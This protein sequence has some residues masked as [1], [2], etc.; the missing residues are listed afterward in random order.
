MYITHVLAY[1]NYLK[2]YGQ[3]LK[4]EAIL[5]E[6]SINELIPIVSANSA[7][8]VNLLNIGMRCLCRYTDGNFYRSEITGIGIDGIISV[9]FCD[10]G[11]EE[12]CH[13]SEVSNFFFLFVYILFCNLFAAMIQLFFFN[14]L[15]SNKIFFI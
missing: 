1:G 9:Y 14:Q 5:V 7:P 10:Y 15:D 3:A 8:S 13:I 4:D 11:N 2:I 6:R 12:K